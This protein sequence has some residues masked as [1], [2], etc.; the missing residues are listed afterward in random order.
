MKN[1]PP[2]LALLVM[3]C[4]PDIPHDPAPSNTIVVQF[5]PGAAV[6]VVPQPNDLAKDPVTGK[7]VVPPS[8]TDSPAQTQFNQQY[9]GTLTGFPFESTASVTVSGDLNPATVTAQD[10]LVIDVTAAPMPVAVMPAYANRVITIAPPAG[11]WLRAHRYA[12]AL[13]AGPN[14]VQGANNETVIGSPTWGLVSSQSSLVTCTDLTSPTCQPAVDV[15]PSNVSDPAQKLAQQ[16]ATAIQLEQLRRGLA[17]LLA[18][19]T[20]PPLSIPR[21]NIPIVWTFTII[22][23]AELTFDPA[24]SVIPFPNDVLRT[25]PNGTVALPNPTTLQPLT[26]ADCQAAT[27]SQIQLVCGLNTLDG[28]STLVAPIS[29]NSNTA[30]ALEQGNIDPASLSTMTVGLVPLTS[31]APMAERTT[32]EFTPCLNCVSSANAMGMPQ[33]TPQQLQWRLDAPLDEKTTYFGYVT[34]GV[35]DSLGKNVIANP[36]FALL[37]SSTPLVANGKST[38]NV[39]TDA[40][41]AQLEPLRAAQAPAFAG[42]ETAGIPR[43][44]VALAFPFTTQSEATL[45]DALY[46]L[47]ALAKAGGLPDFPLTVTDATALYTGA[48][49]AAGIPIGAIGKFFA[50][51]WLTPVAVTGPGGTLNPTAAGIKPQPVSFAMSVPAAPPPA[52]GYPVTIFGHGFTR[53]RNDFL[54]I[55]NALAQAGQVVIATDV[56]FHGDRTSCT[57]SSAATGQPTDDAACANPTTMKCDEGTLQGLC[58]LRDATARLACAPSATDPL[59]DGVCAAAGQ[60]RCAADAKC[61]GAGADLL[62]DATG[63]PLISGW[64]IFSLTNFFATRDNFRQQVIDLSQLVAVLKSTAATNL[65]N[66]IAA[67]NGGTAVPFA[68]TKLGYVGQSLG[69]I[70]GTL[71]NSVSPDTSNVVLNVPGGALVTIILDAPSFAAQKTALL[72]GL[73]AQGIQPGTPAF[74]QFIGLAQWVLDPADPANMGYRLTH[75]VDLGGGTLAPPANRKAFIQFIEGDQTVPNISNFALVTAANRTFVQQPPSFGC[76]P[77]LFCYEFTEAGDGFDTTTAPLANRH[78]FLLAPPSM[79]AG[80]LALTTKAQTQVAT[81]LATGAL[82]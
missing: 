30:G 60:G 37:R 58:V 65:G 33:T 25:G 50:G 56:L 19:L 59:G 27:N 3:S 54:P 78:G 4:T 81:F 73:A 1:L 46:Q 48:A 43:A 64:N 52:G 10:V 68:L 11:G 72:A 14:G 61:Q 40:Q 69:G 12:V 17:P 44:N 31:T 38:V 22:D 35:K 82:P 53:W 18:A 32:P 20:A 47:P 26:A 39:L 49:T 8:P 71:F 28:F 13:V 45:L 79:T 29:E 36:V 5:D 21:A 24:N 9:L 67:K 42:L 74:D 63:R 6:P 77:P 55:A 41:A 23:A 16:T 7:I 66:Q 15:I 2:L 80:G 70:L 34:T 76:V 75:P 57:G 62:R 51:A